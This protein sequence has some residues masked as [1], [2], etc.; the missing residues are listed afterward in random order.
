VKRAIFAL[1]WAPASAANSLCNSARALL[2]DPS[3]MTSD[4]PALFLGSAL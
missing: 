1:P 2:A 3:S 4:R